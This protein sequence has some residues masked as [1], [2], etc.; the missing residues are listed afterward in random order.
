MSGHHKNRQSGRQRAH[1]CYINDAVKSTNINL[2]QIC[3]LTFWVL[4]LPAD[5]HTGLASFRVIGTLDG[6]FV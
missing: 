4:S 6:S 3:S 2:V 5:S 1:Y